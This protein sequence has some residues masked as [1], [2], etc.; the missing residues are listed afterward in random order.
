M[1]NTSR[2][3]SQPTNRCCPWRSATADQGAAQVESGIAAPATE[4][5]PFASR[6]Y[7]LTLLSASQATAPVLL[8]VLSA[9]LST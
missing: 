4:G 9:L 6:L 2:P 8:R 3:L 1:L 5:T 7:G